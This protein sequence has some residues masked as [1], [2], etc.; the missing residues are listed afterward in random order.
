MTENSRRLRGAHDE[1]PD[2][3]LTRQRR[4]QLKQLVNDVVN[5]TPGLNQHD[6]MYIAGA[7]E[8]AARKKQGRAS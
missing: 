1:L 8:D 3:T 6:L 2:A 4:H 5:Y 7:F